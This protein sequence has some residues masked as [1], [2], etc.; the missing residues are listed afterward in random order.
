M[1][2]AVIRHCAVRKGQIAHL[3]MASSMDAG[4]T[5]HM[6][7]VRHFKAQDLCGL[8]PEDLAVVAEQTLAHIAEQ[9]KRVD[10]QAQ[11]IKW[12]DAKTEGIT[13]PPTSMRGAR[14]AFVPPRQ[15][16]SR[17]RKVLAHSQ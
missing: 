5:L 6:L 3:R 9:R 1:I 11:A 10:S 17:P 4:H 7:D 14:A 13:G 16:A 2:L 12:R 15:R 8:S